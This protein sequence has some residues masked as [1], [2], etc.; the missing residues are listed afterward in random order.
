MD[1]KLKNIKY[2]FSAKTVA[3]I[4]AAV[5]FFAA[6]CSANL[7]IRG[8]FF[9]NGYENREF[10]Q[11][12]A[13]R[14]Q[15]N[16]Y[17]RDILMVGER[18]SCKTLEDY[19]KTGQGMNIVE[20]CETRKTE[21][22]SAYNLLESKDIKIYVDA[23]N[24]YRYTYD[25]GRLTYYFR[26]DGELISS[27]EF[28]ELALM[29]VN[30]EQESTTATTVQNSVSESQPS[31]TNVA[32]TPMTFEVT[33]AVTSETTMVD[34]GAYD[35][36]DGRSVP[37]EITEISHALYTLDSISDF[38]C[39]GEVPLDTMLTE[40]ESQYEHA[41]QESF[42]CWYSTESIERVKSVNYAVFYESTGA[43]VSNC[44]ITAADTEE[45]I[46]QKLGGEFVESVKDGQYTLIKG[47]KIPEPCNFF[48]ELHNSFLGDYYDSS[49]LDCYIDLQNYGAKTAYFAYS[50]ITAPSAEEIDG[51]TVSRN[52]FTDYNSKP[53][54]VKN[55]S[56]CL[57]MFA[58][59]LII[60]CALCIYVLGT[61]GKTLAGIKTCFFDRIPLEI[62]WA[63]G[64]L[65]MFL[66]GAGAVVMVVAES[67]PIDYVAGYN[68]GL[69]NFLTIH[70]SEKTDELM[71]L[72]VSVFFL[73]W[74]GLNASVARNIRNKTFLR[75]T[76]CYW[77]IHP[78]RWIWKKTKGFFRRVLNRIKFILAC[79]YS[80]G[81]GK[82]FKT[83]ACCVAAGFV[84]ATIIY[85]TVADVLMRDC[86]EE[87]AFCVYLVGILGDAAIVLFTILIIASLDRIMAGAAQMRNGDLNTQIDT[88]RMPPFMR[89]FADDILSMQ[90]GFQNAVDSAIK[91]QRM[92]AELITNVSHDL[93]TPLTSIVSYVDLLKKCDVQDETAQ[94][95]ISV[96]DEKAAKMK[97]LIEDL[98]EASK[99]STGSVEIHPV[100]INLCEFA[101]QAVGEHEDELK[102]YS[103][104]LVLKTPEQPVTVFADSQKTSRIVE[105]LFSNIR[106]YALDG[107]RVYI[108]VL[109]GSDYG[110]LVFKNISKYPLD[111]PADELTQRFVRG[112][113]SRSGEGSG[114]GLSIAQN[115]CELQK[116]KFSVSIDG[117]LFKVTMAL[118][119][120]E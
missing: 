40:V 17:I 31:Q 28:N 108:E 43:V 101:A 19:K 15:L 98:V 78:L 4:L 11:T 35:P 83:I 95:Y 68:G 107:T 118:P 55:L 12:T 14:E 45:Q 24:R 48:G 73:I 49:V 5:M 62:N 97:K 59:S 103:L 115:L 111:I 36:N 94:K 3:V 10:T 96:L 47:D 70:L 13:F 93:K 119:K 81:K 88:T 86:Y 89:R 117:D 38:T 90:D 87:L 54:P 7:F 99:A 2:S 53:A 58:V 63:L 18:Q 6:G 39:Y 113:S 51:F 32:V 65:T 37:K 56:S 44:G 20:D 23:E 74:T 120:S 50:P 22:T 52:A 82:K 66:A 8:L 102:K 77:L 76:L 72:F 105:N 104:E 29:P 91:D 79:D 116:G 26:F 64:L 42:D 84:V 30:G 92:K 106:K 46:L 67:R 75:R 27:Y 109:S 1:T 21:V 112:D 71:G 69:I 25:F 100:K 60:A 114:L 110:T 33:E 41:L 57:W 16:D 34:R 61:A 85:Y 80:Q 9:Y